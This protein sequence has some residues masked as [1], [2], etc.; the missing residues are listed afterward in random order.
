MLYPTD[1]EWT[2]NDIAAKHKSQ[3]R[4]DLVIVSGSTREGIAYFETLKVLNSLFPL[5]TIGN[6]FNIRSISESCIEFSHGK[7]D[8]YILAEYKSLFNDGYFTIVHGYD[9]GLWDMLDPIFESERIYR[10]DNH[11]VSIPKR[12][13]EQMEPVKLPRP[14]EH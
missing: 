5:E 10:V 6:M 9:S 8:P 12:K 7:P 13:R 11:P 1:T 2:L 3:N 4:D 14:A